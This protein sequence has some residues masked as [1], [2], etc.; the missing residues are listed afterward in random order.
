M[1]RKKKGAEKPTTYKVGSREVKLELPAS[2]AMRAEIF[3]LA[4]SNRSRAAAAALGVCWR[5]NGRPT[6][7]YDSCNYNPAL[8]GGRVMDELIS[9]RG[10]SLGEILEAGTVAL[11]MLSGGLLLAEDVEEAE[12]F[13][14]A[15]GER[16]TG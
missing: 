15:R 6:V 9:E 1:T 13:T 3:L 8:Y 14:E 10:A 16:G 4:S 7:R 2:Y 5:S 11:T 12:G